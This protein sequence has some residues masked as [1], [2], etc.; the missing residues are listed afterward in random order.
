MK[1]KK[2]R[3]LKNSTVFLSILFSSSFS[4]LVYSANYLPTAPGQY[5]IPVTRFTPE[6][7]QYALPPP[8][9]YSHRVPGVS[10]GTLTPVI[11]ANPVN[12]QR[13]PGILP[14]G[15]R[16]PPMGQPVTISPHTRIINPPPQGAQPTPA[17]ITPGVTPLVPGVPVQTQTTTTQIE[18]S[19]K[20]QIVPSPP[21]WATPGAAPGT[22]N[23]TGQPPT[24]TPPIG[25]TT[26]P[27]TT[28]VTTPAPATTT[29]VPTPA[30]PTITTQ[31]PAI[32]VSPTG[33]AVP[34]QTAP[35]PATVVV[36]PGVP[37]APGPATMAPT[38]ITPQGPVGT[39]SGIQPGT[40]EVGGVQTFSRTGN[41]VPTTTYSDFGAH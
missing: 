1:T 36:P 23:V 29:T 15:N 25:T 5:P 38:Q 28:I 19:G 18:S 41:Q 26:T 9:Q 40:S 32:I 34:V 10:R 7:Q 2:Y 31:P 17:I 39:Q 24:V 12:E 37:S 33:P 35:T 3:Y 21:V 14:Q 27:G 11:P 22:A 13:A 4:L 6:P 8:G 20:S 30:S 16:Q